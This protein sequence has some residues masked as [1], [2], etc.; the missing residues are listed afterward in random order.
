MNFQPE[1]AYA[2]ADGAKWVTRRMVSD[3]PRSPYHPDRAPKMVGRRIAVCPG[4][5]QRRIATVEV[6]HVSQ[7]TFDPILID[8]ADARAEGFRAPW[9]FMSA[10]REIHG[11]MNPL[12]VWRIELRRESV[13]IEPAP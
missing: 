13:E 3:N 6:A 5:G 11:N 4:R 1:L 12:D 10:W 7:E 2:V 8:Y 9:A